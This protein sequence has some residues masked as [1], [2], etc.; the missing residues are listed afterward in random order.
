MR[1]E[2]WGGVQFGERLR[3]ARR[4]QGM[5]LREVAEASKVSVAY[6]SDLERGVLKN[7]SLD[8]LTA[9]ASALGVSPNDLLGMPSPARFPAPM[10]L[11]EFAGSHSFR[12]ALL[13]DAPSMGVPPGELG[14]EWM[15]ILG[16]IRLFGRT[17]P[18]ASDY[19]FLFEAMRRA[20]RA[21]G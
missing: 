5:T 11:E 6:L 8:K 7:P 2:S 3:R 10:A 18:T 1:T 16:Q 9:I 20:L 4:R 13:V 19:A 14:V 15:R 17:P 21:D 12:D